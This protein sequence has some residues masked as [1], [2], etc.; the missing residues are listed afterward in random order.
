[1]LDEAMRDA[2]K[3]REE[4]LRNAL[5]VDEWDNDEVSEETKKEFEAKKERIEAIMHKILS[6]RLKISDNPG[7]VGKINIVLNYN[8]ITY[9]QIG[10]DDYLKPELKPIIIL[11]NSFLKRVASEQ[12]LL[13]SEIE[14]LEE[15]NEQ[16]CDK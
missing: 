9:S 5:D 3:I 8:G 11:I 10:I 13:P 15:L 4:A 7:R 2:K 6:L 16:W 1:M 14:Y 12:T